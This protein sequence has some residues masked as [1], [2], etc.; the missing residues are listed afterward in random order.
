MIAGI[1]EVHTEVSITAK[2]LMEAFGYQFI[3]QQVKE[4]N[5]QKF[6]NYIMKKSLKK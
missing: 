6:V 4:H 1:Q 2:P 3:T 5:G